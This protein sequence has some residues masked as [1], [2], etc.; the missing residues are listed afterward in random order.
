MDRFPR[1][2][3][4]ERSIRIPQSTIGH[5]SHALENLGGEAAFFFA[6]TMANTLIFRKSHRNHLRDVRGKKENP[7]VERA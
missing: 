4:C 6:I 3:P 5:R 1:E 2:S 7:C